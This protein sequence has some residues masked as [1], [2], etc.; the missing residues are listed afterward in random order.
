MLSAHTGDTRIRSI[1]CILIVIMYTVPEEKLRHRRVNTG[2]VLLLTSRA[3]FEPRQ[4]EPEVRSY[5]P[6]N[7]SL[8]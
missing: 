8:L 1:R 6:G 4:P 5:C 3:G 2:G 7:K